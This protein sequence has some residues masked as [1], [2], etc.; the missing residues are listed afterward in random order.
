MDGTWQ[1]LSSSVKL[2]CNLLTF[3]NTFVFLYYNGTSFELIGP[4]DNIFNTLTMPFDIFATDDCRLFSANNIFYVI[5]NNT[6]M[7]VVTNTTLS[8][9]LPH[10]DSFD[11]VIRGTQL[12]A[13]SFDEIQY[14]FNPVFSSIPSGSNCKIKSYDIIVLAVCSVAK[15]LNNTTVGVDV[16]IFMWADFSPLTLVSNQTYSYVAGNGQVSIS[17]SPS[18]T[19]VFYSYT[20]PTKTLTP[21]LKNVSLELGT[22]TDLNFVN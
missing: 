9:T 15:S 2:T 6:I 21:V 14:A 4:F 11:Y 13:L 5:E 12:F 8:P 22:F 18:L 1:L 7:T 3:N 10:T 16:T 19:K 20:T 17:I